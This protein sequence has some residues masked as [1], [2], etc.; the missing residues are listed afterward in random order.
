MSILEEN[1]TQRPL[2]EVLPEAFMGYSKFVILHRA[3]PDVRDG[4]KPVHRRIIY[5]MHELGMT[6]D[7]PHSK[8]AR[9]VGHC[10]GAYH[11]HGD[12]AIYE[13]AVR[14]AQPW[15][16]RY[17]FI[18]GHGNFGSVDGDPAAAM[19][20][21]EM[22]MTPLAK[23]MCQDLEKD[24]VSFRPN[25]D[26]RLEEPAVLPSPL[27]SLL[28]NGTGGIAVGLATNMPP[29]NLREVIRG[30]T[31]Q[32]DNPELTLEELMATVPGP[33]FP[34]GG[35]ILGQDGIREAYTTGRGKLIVRGKA[36]I[37]PGKGGKQLI[38]ITEIPYQVNKANLAGKIESL[39][40]GKIEGIADVRDESDREGMRLVVECR[41]EADPENILAQLYKYTQLQESFGIINLVITADGTPKI[42]NL[43]ELNQAYIEH[44]REVVIR[45]TEYDLKK[46]RARAHIL[47]G[48]VVAIKNLDEVIALIRASKTPA[49]AKAALIL[50][51]EFSDLQAQAVLDMKLQHLTNLELESILKEYDEVL[52]LISTL[53]DILAHESKIYDIIK[54]ELREIA[55]QY[56][57]ER[58]TRILTEEGGMGFVLPQ[59]PESEKSVA[60]FLTRDG[61][62][63]TM[64]PGKSGRGAAAHPAAFKDGDYLIAKALGTDR[65]TLFFFS[66]TGK[67][68]SLAGKLIPEAGAK[69]KGKVLSALLPLPED[70]ELLTL[71]PLRENQDGYFV[72]V[73]R[74]GQ[75]MRTAVSEFYHARTPEAITLKEGDALVNV[76]FSSGENELFLV[77]AK[78]L[79]IRYSENQVN[80]MGRKAR[81][82]RGMTLEAGDYVAAAALITPVHGDLLSVTERGW[83]KRT[84]LDAYKP[85]GR[86]GKGVA[87]GRVSPEKTGF[88]AAIAPIAAEPVL[89][90]IQKGGSTTVIQ[91]SQLEREARMKPGALLADV[92][93]DDYVVQALL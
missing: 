71:V 43:K 50:R 68:Y 70:A 60:F 64:P 32:I 5:S 13:A 30:I 44:R 18:D 61:F 17:Q 6:P 56:G 69:E 92:M 22:R 11:P 57:D 33:D 24:T 28:V 31:Q 80:P 4:L 26:N 81:G 42:L 48:L 90:L 72:F 84:S 55:D 87:L 41:K 7:K 63:K 8:S 89:V 47:E 77:S 45:R 67:A 15:A 62:V 49:L 76:F 86:G 19:R 29:H 58:R 3:I 74:D 38:V 21:T 88:V 20:Y 79:A 93:L 25:Y 36:A 39:A 78:G 34:T 85:Q 82:V 12:S 37:Q 65:D 40:D 16:S 23:L 83:V 66:R 59:V 73:T 52:R 27:P 53:E 14:M 75:I 35:Y 51:F 1:I 54:K 10:M 2:E 91:L 9:L 46:A